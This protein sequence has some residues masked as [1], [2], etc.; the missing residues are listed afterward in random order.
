MGDKC[1]VDDEKVIVFIGHIIVL[2]SRRINVL[3]VRLSHLEQRMRIIWASTVLKIA[4]HTW[5][6]TA[7]TYNLYAILQ[8][9]IV[10]NLTAIQVQKLNEDLNKVSNK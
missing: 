1:D 7:G 6:M 4:I 3:W 9:S 8:L 5:S 2:P 10:I